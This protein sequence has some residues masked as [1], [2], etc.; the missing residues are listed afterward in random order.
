[1]T[2]NR[3]IVREYCGKCTKQIYIGKSAIVCH[4][5]DLISHST[6]LTNYTIFREKIFYSACINK[7][8]IL[9]Y[10]PFYSINRSDNQYGG[11][12]QRYFRLF[13]EHVR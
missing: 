13:W 4:E 3:N 5:C 7:H 6:C 9:R 12:G 10:N 1:M 2:S 11:G 8:D